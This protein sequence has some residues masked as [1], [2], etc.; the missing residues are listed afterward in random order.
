MEVI[1][2]GKI[3]SIYYEDIE[4]FTKGVLAFFEN[5][6]LFEEQL[7]SLVTLNFR[8]VGC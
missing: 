5:P 8:P 4:K 3:N 6:Y 1:E 2:K 7:K